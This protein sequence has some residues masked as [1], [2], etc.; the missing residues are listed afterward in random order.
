VLEGL[1]SVDEHDGD[2][3]AVLGE[4]DRIRLDVD[5]HEL[6]G[7]AK[8]N[9]MDRYLGFVTERAVRFRIDLDLHAGNIF[10][11]RGLHGDFNTMPL[12]A[13]VQFLADRR[14]TGMLSL[15]RSGVR[16]QAE[17]VD[18]NI[19]NTSSSDPREF[20]GQFLINLGHIT[21][22]QF[23][24]AYETQ[25]ETKI[26]LGKILVMI[27]AVKDEAVQMALS[28]KFR[29]TVLEAFQWR[30]GS[31][32]FDAGSRGPPIEGLEFSI[33]LA[34]IAREA[35]FRETAWQAIRG[36]F[37]SG[38]VKLVAKAQN[39]PEPPKPGSIDAKVFDLIRE[40]H[41]IDEIAL[42]LHATDFFLYQRLYALYRLEAVDVDESG[43]IDEIPVEINLEEDE[44]AAQELVAQVRVYIDGGQWADAEELARRA[45]QLSP[46]LQTAELLREAEA[47]LLGD[48]RASVLAGRK[49]PR[50]NV[51]PSKVKTMKLSAPERYLLSRF[52]GKRELRSIVQVSPIREL[53][54]LKFIR[55]FIDA[56][57]VDLKAA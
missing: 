51:A 26:F 52:D 13:L 57:L 12:S 21:E 38:G 20:L 44:A 19:I 5:L 48:L 32:A 55:Q 23:N 25:Q 9:S 34:D 6:E 47:K 30:D 35:E 41:S 24:K 11:V 33:S 29:E 28:L 40:A 36:A 53:D 15:E 2:V 8:A 1:P 46:S 7:N 16:K 37:P 49:I 42:A 14:A 18:G 43:L 56:G 45:H 3:V 39:L 22:E 31:F 27:G 54:A 17:L 10:A 4:K 50:L